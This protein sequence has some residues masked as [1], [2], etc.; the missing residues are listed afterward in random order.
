M[1]SERRVQRKTRTDENLFAH[2]AAEIKQAT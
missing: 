2:L 1:I